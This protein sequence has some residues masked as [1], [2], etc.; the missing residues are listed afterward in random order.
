MDLSKIKTL[1]DFVGQSNITELTV[2]EKDT[3]VRIFRNGKP[4]ATSAAAAKPAESAAATKTSTSVTSPIF[5]LLHV[6][7]APG[8]KAFV[9]LGDMVEVGQT[10]FIIEAMKVFNSITAPR[11]GRIVSIDAADGAEVEVGDLLAEIA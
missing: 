4:A 1:I 3:T 10:L 7:P 11:A 9:A 6:A 2:T 8:E 5:G